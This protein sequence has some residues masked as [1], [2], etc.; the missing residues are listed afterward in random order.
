MRPLFLVLMLMIPGA[1]AQMAEVSKAPTNQTEAVSVPDPTTRKAASVTETNTSEEALASEEQPEETIIFSE[2]TT[3]EK[4]G[5]TAPPEAAREGATAL[6]VPYDEQAEFIKAKI[7]EYFPGDEMMICIAGEE[8]TGYIHW[9]PDGS[10]RPTEILKPDGSPAST[11]EGVLQTLV[12][13]HS[14]DIANRGLNMANIDEYM[15][16]NRY[17]LHTQGYGA[18]KDSYND[19]K[20]K[21]YRGLEVMAS[22]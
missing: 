2:T 21:G 3:E 17:L 16:F 7:R 11:A 9:L 15:L 19:C 22:N 6:P 18:W 20:A 8:S 13:L 12:G 4:E 10:L 14:E 5:A 1:C